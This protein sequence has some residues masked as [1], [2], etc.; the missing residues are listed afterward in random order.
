MALRSEFVIE[1]EA[2]E[3]KN[4]CKAFDT[5]STEACASLFA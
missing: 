1:Q 3:A 2:H 4:I 5:F